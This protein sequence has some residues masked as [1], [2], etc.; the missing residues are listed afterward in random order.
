M[1]LIVDD[2][3]LYVAS[4]VKDLHSSLEEGSCEGLMFAQVHNNTDIA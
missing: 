1:V 3:D 2:E 4:H